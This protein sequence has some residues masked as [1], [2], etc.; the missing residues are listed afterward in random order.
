MASPDPAAPTADGQP[1][2]TVA[3]PARTIAVTVANGVPTTIT[4]TAA[5]LSGSD[6]DVCAR[7]VAVCRFAVARDDAQRAEQLIEAA[8]ARGDDPQRSWL[9]MHR[10]HGLPTS[11]AVTESYNLHY[12]LG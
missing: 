11:D 2:V 3:D 1:S 4:V 9:L 7:I 12:Q 6:A 5:A 10:H 8:V